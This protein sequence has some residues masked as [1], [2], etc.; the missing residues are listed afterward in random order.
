MKKLIFLLFLFLLFFFSREQTITKRMIR[1]ADLYRLPTIGDAQLSPDGKWVAYVLTKVDSGKDKRDADIWMVS[2]DGS[3]HIQI[4]NSPEGESK[5]RWSPDSKYLSFLSSRQESKGSQVWLLD[6]RGGEGKRITEVKGGIN[7]YAWSPDG[8]KLALV[9]TEEPKDTAKK[10]SPKPIIVNRYHFKADIAGYLNN[11]HSHLYLFDI[12]TKKLDTLTKGNYDEASPAW[13][14]DGSQIAFV[15][16][17]TTEPDRNENTDI[18]I[19]DAKPGSKMIQ[20]TFW[21]GYDNS[22]QWSPDG[23]YIAY[24]RS[25]SSENYIMYDQPQLAVISK[26]GGEPKLLTASLDRPV[27]NPRWARDGRSVAGLVTDNRERYIA[28][29]PLTGGQLTIIAGG[30]CSYGSLENGP[31]TSWLAT[32][33]DPQLPAEIFA[34]ESGKPRRLTSQMVDFLSPLS[35]ASVEGFI[36]KS[37]DGTLVSGILYRPA[38]AKPGQRLPL[39]LFIHGGPV[40]QDDWGFDLTRQMLAGANYAVAAVNYRGSSGRGLDYCKIIAAD[41]GNKEVMDL[42]GAVDHLV[43]QG[44][45]DP[46]K[47][48]VGGWS[49]GGILTDYLIASDTRFKAAASGAGTG[50]ALALYGVDQ[51]IT[52]YDNEIGAPWKH[53]DKYLKISYPFLKADRIKT[54]TLFMSGEKDFNV[55][56]AGSEQM[57]QALRS[58]GTATELIVYPGQF[59][60]ITLP[61]YQVDRYERYIAWYDKYVNFPAGH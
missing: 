55:P 42:Q 12:V 53:I 44:I 2:W 24:L 43:N 28:L 56:T 59:H 9:I 31:D 50:F 16:N 49:Y 35:L 52:Q 45:A 8:K 20:L 26:D 5:P 57:Y 22:P 32:R 14:P 30:N 1:P 27:S 13:S 29:F 17:R 23:K 15:S 41:W 10:T 3:Q 37:K 6:R 36:S 61:S 47:L 19:I 33:S 46:D 54:P 60:G 51:Y 21:T 48:G 4:T 7:D 25:T 38:G 18:F 11:L 58:L 40:G 34:L 39:I